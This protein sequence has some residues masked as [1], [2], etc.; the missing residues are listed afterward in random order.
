M[1]IG[2]S[3]DE[4]PYL[5]LFD[6]LDAT[7]LE[8]LLGH[9][10]S[11]FDSMQPST[12]VAPQTFAISQDDDIRRSRVDPEV[13][14][15][16]PPFE[17]RLT[18]L[19]PHLRRELGIGYFPLGSL[20]RQLTVHSDGDFFSRHLDENDPWTDGCRMITFVYYFNAEPRLFEGG[21]LRIY[22]VATDPDGNLRPADSYTEIEPISNSIVFFP[23]DRYHEVVPVRSGGEGPGAIRCTI[24]GWYRA[25]NLGRPA[26]PSIEPAVL[27]LLGARYLPRFSDSGFSLRPTPL[28]VQGLLDSRWESGQGDIVSESADPAYFPNG[29]PNFLPLGPLGQEILDRLRAVHERWAGVPLRPVAAYGMR[30]YRSGQ[31]VDMHIDRPGTHVISSMLAV[32]QDV[33][34]PWPLQLDIAER[35]HELYVQPGQMLLYEGA[36]SPH[37]H[38]RKLSGRCYAVA[39]MHYCPLDWTYSTESLAR[40]ALSDG[41]IDASGRLLPILRT[42][43]R[44]TGEEAIGRRGLPEESRNG[45][46]TSPR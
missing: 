18:D 19:L 3:L 24:N 45:S 22:D 39:L 2:G 28:P 33:D 21:Q 6:F 29:D 7:E 30:I 12:V 43:P 36:S 32:A 13:E 14:L 9:V 26:Q 31:S 4:A 15:V 11:R 27:N 40:R 44:W 25:G 41:L 8:L 23:S 5:Q 38:L 16:W 42:D 10:A 35:R 17:K 46:A 34:D 20:E 37:G 1:T